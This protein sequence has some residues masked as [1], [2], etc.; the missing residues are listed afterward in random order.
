M[1]AVWLILK[2]KKKKKNWAFCKRAYEGNVVAWWVFMG[3]MGGSLKDASTKIQEVGKAAF[4]WTR[5]KGER[6]CL[7]SSF[8]AA[9]FCLGSSQGFHN[10]YLL[11]HFSKSIFTIMEVSWKSNSIQLFLPL[12]ALICSKNIVRFVIAFTYE[13]VSAHMKVERSRSTLCQP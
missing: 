5:R 10:K 1:T 11:H 3:S 8:L 2:K 4:G 9:H 6:P 13:G 7:L 12:R